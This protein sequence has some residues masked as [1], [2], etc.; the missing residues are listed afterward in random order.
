MARPPRRVPGEGASPPF[1]AT[2]EEDSNQQPAPLEKKRANENFSNDVH[3][4]HNVHTPDPGSSILSAAREPDPAPPRRNAR[5]GKAKPDPALVKAKATLEAALAS[6]EPDALFTEQA[7]EA[8]CL[9]RGAA[10]P[11]L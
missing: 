4:V 10:D 3:N 1:L 6:K 8:I 7:V 11:S 9:I 2:L 5:A